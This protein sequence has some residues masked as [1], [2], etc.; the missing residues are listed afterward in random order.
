VSIL[1]TKKLSLERR[2][3]N[4]ALRRSGAISAPQCHR[5]ESK[6]VLGG[7]GRLTPK[8]NR[9]ARPSRPTRA[10]RLPNLRRRQ[11]LAC[12][13]QA[14]GEPAQARRNDS[15]AIG[16]RPSEIAFPALDKLSQTPRAVEN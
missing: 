14:D 10:P 1:L 2:P 16:S 11:D 13:R 6:E 12:S 3:V 9:I 5:V 15:G 7:R 8:E 4:P